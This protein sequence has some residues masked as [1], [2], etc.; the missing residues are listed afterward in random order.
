LNGSGRKIRVR[1]RKCRE[2]GRRRA[3][4]VWIKRKVCEKPRRDVSAEQERACLP[5]PLLALYEPGGE[6]QSRARLKTGILLPF[7]REHRFLRL[8]I[9]VCRPPA[10][11]ASARRFFSS[12]VLLH[13]SS[14]GQFTLARSETCALTS[15]SDFVI[16]SLS[17]NTLFH[18]DFFFFFFAHIAS[19]RRELSCVK[20]CLPQNEA[21]FE[22]ILNITTLQQTR[23]D[24]GV[25]QGYL[26]SLRAKEF[27]FQLFH[28]SVWI[29]FTHFCRV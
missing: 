27:P 21:A 16:I 26:I 1:W 9:F 25:F 7:V 19:A 8:F 20:S 5:Q 28:R 12:P 22:R 6:R 13:Y 2:E 10:T 23:R 24:C 18:L 3:G 4:S 11:L 15:G 17:E 14:V 29:L